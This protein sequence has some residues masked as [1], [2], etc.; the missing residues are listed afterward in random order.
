MLR[1]PLELT[2]A[3]ILLTNDDGIHAP[4]LEALE[5]V[6]RS[7]SDDVWVVAPET[8]QSATTTI[9]GRLPSTTPPR[10]SGA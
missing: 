6:A 7:L 4:G 3:R 2:G 9:T 10:C 5:R 8:E 1:E